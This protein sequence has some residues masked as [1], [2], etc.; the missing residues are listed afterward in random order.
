MVRVPANDTDKARGRRGASDDD[1]SKP[2]FDSEN[3]VVLGLRCDRL[4]QFLKGEGLSVVQFAVLL[5]LDELQGAEVPIRDL[6]AL[7][8]VAPNVVTLAANALEGRGYAARRVLAGDGRSKYLVITPEG[9]RFLARADDELYALLDDLFAPGDDA[10]ARAVLERGLRV[11]A[12]VGD[13]WSDELVETYPSAA[14]LVSVTMF[15]REVERVLRDAAG[16]TLS[17]G[18]VLQCLGEVATPLRIGDLSWRLRLPAATITRASSKLEGEGLLE[19]L[20]SPHDHK[21]I[22]VRLTGEGGKRA[23]LIARELDRL[24]TEQY[25][26]RLDSTDLAVTEEIKRILL[27]SIRMDEERERRERLAV[28]E[29]VA[30]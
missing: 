22:Y 26:G 3:F 10:E 4:A 29:S 13:L 19:R 14:N 18:R 9:K 23:A 1:A 20:S 30:R 27:G 5:K 12:G 8:R 28:L 21:A 16:V 11:G 15:L 25:W 17:E 24:G 7:V 2:V 6:A